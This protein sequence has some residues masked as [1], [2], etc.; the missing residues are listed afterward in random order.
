MTNRSIIF[1][2]PMLRAILE[3]RKTQT[4][5]VLKP[6]PSALEV[7][8]NGIFGMTEYVSFTLCHAGGANE[9]QTVR[10]PYAPGDTLWV[11]ETW[12][13]SI[14]YDDLMPSELAGEEPY[15]Y[16]ADGSVETWGWQG[17][18]RWGRIRSPIHMPR[19]ASRLTLRVTDVRVQR[20][21]EISEGDAFAEGVEPDL[22]CCGNPDIEYDLSDHGEPINP[23]QGDCCGSPILA[24]DPRETFRDIWNSIN[25]KR[26]FG[27]G[28]NP[29]VAAITFEVVDR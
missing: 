1:S 7:R 14:A 18:I 12:K 9:T 22:Q 23:R 25:A 20:V 27:W 8:L 29:W 19:W 10:L 6:Q 5:R 2:G 26:G 4:R 15:K 16:L 11:K 13:T 21:Q 17:P 24:S 28:D 3:G